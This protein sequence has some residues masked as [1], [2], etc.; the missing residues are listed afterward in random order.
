[1]AEQNHAPHDQDAKKDRK[2]SRYPTHSQVNPQ[3]PNFLPRCLP[4]KVLATLHLAKDQGFK[5]ALLRNTQ[6][7]NSNRVI[8][9]S[10][11]RDWIPWFSKIE[12]EQGAAR[13]GTY[14]RL[15]SR[16]LLN[17]FFHLKICFRNQHKC[18]M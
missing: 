9:E 4:L 1:M 13:E 14:L 6:E 16:G 15:S 5:H 2:V 18:H 10:R 8:L 12:D 17:L 3:S 11:R 7:P